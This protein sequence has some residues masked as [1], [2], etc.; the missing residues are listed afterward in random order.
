MS[1]ADIAAAVAA[2]YWT[3]LLLFVAFFIGFVVVRAQPLFE[4]RHSRSD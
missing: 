2:R 4:Q 3:K 1:G